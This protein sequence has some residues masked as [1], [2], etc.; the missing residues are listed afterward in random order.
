[1]QVCNEDNGC[2]GITFTWHRGAHPPKV[3]ASRGRESARIFILHDRHTRGEE[4]TAKCP[5]MNPQ[6]HKGGQLQRASV[7]FARVR[8]DA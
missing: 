4:K 3:S 2:D 6:R 1:M 5:S 8:R 7:A